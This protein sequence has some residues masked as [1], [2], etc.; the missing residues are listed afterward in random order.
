M[1]PVSHKQF[2]TLVSVLYII[3]YI[4]TPCSVISAVNHLAKCLSLVSSS[5]YH[6]IAL[7]CLATGQRKNSCIKEFN[8]GSLGMVKLGYCFVTLRRHVYYLPDPH[9]AKKQWPNKTNKYVKCF[10][11]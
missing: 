10:G 9:K 7:M 2:S 3:I 6:V 5:S 8:L 11:L 1:L 4:Y